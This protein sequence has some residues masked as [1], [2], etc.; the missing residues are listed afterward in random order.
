[1]STLCGGWAASQ[2]RPDVACVADSQAHKSSSAESSAILETVERIKPPHDWCREGVSMPILVQA[3]P[4]CDRNPVPAGTSIPDLHV[5]H[6]FAVELA[7]I[8][9]EVHGARTDCVYMRIDG[10]AAEIE[11]ARAHDVDVKRIGDAVGDAHGT[12]TRDVDMR[13]AVDMRGGH[14]ARTRDV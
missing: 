7:A 4:N 14:V 12:R 10:D 3:G 9:F 6:A 2:S 8:G 11:I 1:M 13:R 5:R